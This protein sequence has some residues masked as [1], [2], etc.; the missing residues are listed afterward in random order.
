M[1][2]F[3]ALNP[4][5]ALRAA[6]FSTLFDHLVGP[7]QQGQ[8]NIDSERLRGLEVDNKLDLGRSL[9]G[10]IAWPLPLENSTGIDSGLP[11]RCRNAV[12][13]SDQAAG[14]SKFAGLLDR[15]HC[16][17]KRQLGKL[18]TPAVEERVVADQERGS[19][20]LLHCCKDHIK[21]R[22]ALCLQHFEL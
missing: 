5:Y 2:G 4:T 22:F 9:H 18:N 12:A 1:L 21:I 10:K 13:V 20:K 6:Q 19:A 8:R 14:H 7:A 17:P 15:R 16:M 3:A 11:I